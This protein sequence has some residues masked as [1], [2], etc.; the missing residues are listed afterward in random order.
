MDALKNSESVA[1][2]IKESP[3]YAHIIIRGMRLKSRDSNM[4]REAEEPSNAVLKVVTPC[5]ALINHKTKTNLLR[6][7]NATCILDWR[8]RTQK[9]NPR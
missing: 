6:K 7:E 1:T 3:D 4:T 5:S 8:K 2:Q 9:G